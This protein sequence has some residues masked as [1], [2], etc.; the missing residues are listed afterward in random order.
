MQLFNLVEAT[1]V[2]SK[3]KT[4]HAYAVDV[5]RQICEG[6]QATSRLKLS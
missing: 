6:K 5:E 4:S 2:H 3:Q 1:I